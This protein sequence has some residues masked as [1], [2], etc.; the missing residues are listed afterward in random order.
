MIVVAGIGNQLCTYD[1]RFL[2]YPHSSQSSAPTKPYLSFPGYRNRDLNG[3]AVGFDVKGSLI[4]AGTDDERV[5]VLDGG[6][7]LELQTGAGGG[8]GR[9]KLAGTARCVKLT[10]G[11]DRGEEIRLYVA[12]GANIEEWAW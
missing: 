5:Q 1:L 11:A 9:E 12:A 7:G 8:L 6:T 4:A 3:L 10:D 2:T